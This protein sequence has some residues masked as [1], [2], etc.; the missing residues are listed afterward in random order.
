VKKMH[1]YWSRE[2]HPAP[3]I[4]VQAFHADHSAMD[5]YMLYIEAE[6][7][8]ILFT[9]DFRDHGIQGEQLWKMLN[10]YVVP[11]GVDILITEGTMLGREQV[12]RNKG[13]VLT[14]RE[15]GQRAGALFREHKY[16][17]VLVSST[18]F[19]SV[20]EFYHNTPPEMPFV[21]DFYQAR[22]I[23]T[24]MEGMQRL[25]YRFPKYMACPNYREYH[26][27]PTHP[28]LRV[29]DPVHSKWTAVR[30]R[31]LQLKH[32]LDLQPITEEELE[33]DGFVLLARKNPKPGEYTSPFERLR[34]RF[35][36]RD[37]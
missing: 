10:R 37:G 25:E 22:L 2:M 35:M 12:S 34:D 26:A 36:E 4:T 17:F 3:G 29:L 19:D 1:T 14:E 33:H 11:K 24:A 30:R 13:T 31:G 6:G 28:V 21:C 27:S 23:I 16:N 9:G 5:A 8:R 20:M 18:N 15:L 7:K 32:P